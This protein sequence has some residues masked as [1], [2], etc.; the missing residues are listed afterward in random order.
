[1]KYQVYGKSSNLRLLPL[2]K[3]RSPC[4]GSSIRWKRTP[5]W[6]EVSHTELVISIFSFTIGDA[7]FLKVRQDLQIISRLVFFHLNQPYIRNTHLITM[8]TRFFARMFLI[9]SWKHF[10]L[11]QWSW[12]PTLMFSVVMIAWAPSST[13]R[14][15]RWTKSPEKISFKILLTITK[16]WKVEQCQS[17]KPREVD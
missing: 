15:F 10:L 3:E 14:L 8:K 9:G 4:L 16:S 1:M 12:N 2:P 11:I 7:H 5:P 17:Q 13:C 6:E